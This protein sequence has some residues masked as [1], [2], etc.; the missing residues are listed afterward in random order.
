[1]TFG[2]DRIINGGSLSTRILYDS[3]AGYL[4]LLLYHIL[5]YVFELL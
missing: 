2:I 5:F 4:T 3:E 1:M